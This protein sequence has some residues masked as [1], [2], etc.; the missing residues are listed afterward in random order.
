MLYELHSLAGRGVVTRLPDQCTVE[1][2]P[3]D[4]KEGPCPVAAEDAWASVTRRGEVWGRLGAL[5]CSRHPPRT[6]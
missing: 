1:R 5:S 2:S 3:F 4:A 6:R